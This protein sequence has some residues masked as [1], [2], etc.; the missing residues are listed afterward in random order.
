MSDTLIKGKSV[1]VVILCECVCVNGRDTCNLFSLVYYNNKEDQRLLLR[2]N[3]G[4]VIKHVAY[5]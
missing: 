1:L 3:N 4:K 2:S 5:L